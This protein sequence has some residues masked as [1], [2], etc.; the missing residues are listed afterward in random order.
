MAATGS[1]F[2]TAGVFMF[3]DRAMSVPSFPNTAIAIP[4]ACVGLRW[5]TLA[6][7][8]YSHKHSCTRATHTHTM[9][10]PDPL[11]PRSSSHHRSP[12]DR[13]LLRSTPETQG[14][15]GLRVRHHP[16][17]IS[18]GILWLLDRALWDLRSL[19][20]LLVYDSGVRGECTGYRAVDTAGGG[21]VGDWAE[22]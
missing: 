8:L 4:N 2:L 1:F 12:K 9:S 3:F 15:S 10:P 7:L 13:P 6:S 17:P 19:R 5:E 14:H 18:M 11:P 22:E 20:R 21:E 16:D